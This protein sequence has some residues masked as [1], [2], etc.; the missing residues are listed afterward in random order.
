M[1][2]VKIVIKDN[3]GLGWFENGEIVINARWI[4]EWD[5]EQTIAYTFLHEYLE[6]VLRLGHEK[7]EYAEITIRKLLEE[8]T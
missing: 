1:V 7:A 5:A 2:D 8:T 6:H 4:Y 3:D